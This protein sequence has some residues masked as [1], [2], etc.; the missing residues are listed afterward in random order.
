M[1]INDS[2]VRNALSRLGH[3]A[4]AQIVS[5]VPED[6]AICEFDC[7]ESQCSSSNW[8]TCERRISKTAGELGPAVIQP[9]HRDSEMLHD[10][11]ISSIIRAT[12]RRA[13]TP[14]RK[15][16]PRRME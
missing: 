13:N 8:M 6:L 16:T 3:W 2:T 7:R 5:E 14:D 9:K 4:K 12:T 15:E 1:P 11:T 10:R